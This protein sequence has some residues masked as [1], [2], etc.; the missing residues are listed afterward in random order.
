MY[1]W[2]LLNRLQDYINSINDY[3][4]RCV[5]FSCKIQMII[6]V[7]LI[8]SKPVLFDIANAMIWQD[9]IRCS[10]YSLVEWKSNGSYVQ[11]HIEN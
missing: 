1:E 9:Q 11:V 10:T 4:V 7:A 2:K 3:I 6:K 8:S 5:N